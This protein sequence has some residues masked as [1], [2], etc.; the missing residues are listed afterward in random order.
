MKN[1]K[2]CDKDGTAW[3]YPLNYA[4]AVSGTPSDL[5]ALPALDGTLGAGVTDIA[6]SANA[7]YVVRR[8]RQ[9]FIY[10]L[11]E[12][13]GYRY[14]RSYMVLEDSFL[15][16][17]AAEQ[18]PTAPVEFTCERNACGV[19]ASVIG[20]EKVST[21]DNVWMMFVPTAMT[22]A[23]LDEYRSNAPSYA[24]KGKMRYFDAKGWVAGSRAQPHTLKPEQLMSK[25]V[26]FIL[27]RQH[28]EAL[29]SPLGLAMTRQLFPAPSD[30]YAGT[31]ANPDGSENGFLGVLAKKLAKQEA[32]VLVLDDHIGITQELNDFRNAPLEGL[33]HYLAATDE[34]GASNQQRLQVY[35]AIQ[36][37]K[38][39]LHSGIVNDRQEFL[40]LHQASSDQFFERRRSQASSLRAQG[41]FAD[42]AAIESD[43]DRGLR[44]RASNYR[45]EME[46]AKAGAAQ[47]WKDKYESRLDLKEMSTFYAALNSR[48]KAAFEA[49]AKRAD[50]HLKWFESD[51][52]VKAF[53]AF[54]KPDLSTLDK[55]KMSAGYNFAMESALCSFGLS[56][57]KLGEDKIDAWINAPQ[58]ER[59]NL[60]MRGLYHNS[61]ELIAAAKQAFIDIKAATEPEEFASGIE[62]THILKATKG[63]IDG[64][65]KVDSAFDEWARNQ[66]QAYSKRWN[67]SPEIVLYHKFSDITRT[68][69][70]AGMGGTFDKVITA[71]LSGWLY[72]RLG[73][74]VGGLAYDEAM[75]KLPKEKIASHRAE[76]AAKRAE[77]RR[78]D[79][80][81]DKAAKVVAKIDGS[82][83]VLIADAQARAR[84]KALTLN[85]IRGTPA[86]Q[87][88]TNNYHQA[89]IGVLLG[90]IEMIAL[91]EKLSHFENN[92]KG[93]L[94]VGGSAMAVGSIVLDTYYSAAKSLRE[95]KPYRDVV[96][97]NKGAD[98]VRG[99]FK[100]G[101]GV[102]GFGAGICGAVL[103]IMKVKGTEDQALKWVYGL[104][105]ATGFVSAGLTITA[106]FSYCSP[107]LQKAA[108]GFAS[109]SVRFKLLQFSATQAAKLALRVRLL[110]WV[111]RLNWAGLA[112]TA[113]EIGYLALKDDDLQNWCEMCVFRKDKKH[114]NWLGREVKSEHFEGATRELEV[115]ERSAQVVGGG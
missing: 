42:A 112:L 96:A 47:K 8:P 53:D 19:G 86:D 54:D 18:P 27:F 7:R 100:L 109:H 23:K 76:R 90:C 3:V 41:R 34:Y 85:Q 48:S 92:T 20:I 93:W 11:I 107:M 74:V 99:Q 13:F 79:K 113:V 25:A 98:I 14:W 46:Q 12:R 84:E 70:R 62:S 91:G 95:I 45:A 9:G 35:E 80:A 29:T 60:Y 71:C 26:E 88:P 32:A 82:L 94:E 55:A 59:K 43:V 33:E 104:R 51:R 22:K 24:S 110:V 40:A 1:C 68:V 44:A 50:D 17:F 52:L 65:K 115:L 97:I 111:A 83:E 5:A 61:D 10:V 78:M 77:T 75:L 114:K 69:F 21:V 103:D 38:A 72:A 37:V 15:Y 67:A 89:R 81:T 106:A 28:K 87:L 39:G 63:L 16:E 2:F 56:S 105:A 4:V 57:C 66:G 31:P 64:F 36:E 73:A 6:L 49:G 108:K 101:A 102:L 58:A 30:A